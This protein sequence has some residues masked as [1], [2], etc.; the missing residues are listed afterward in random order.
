MA[1][2][3]I[4]FDTSVFIAHLRTGKHKER[5]RTLTGLVRNSSVVLAELLRGATKADE[6]NFVVELAKNHP[7]F[8]PSENNW[9]DSGR[10]LSAV[11]K[12]KGFS[13]DKLR[14]LHFDA[15]IAL[16]ARSHGATVITSDRT[17]FE[18]IRA[19]KDFNLEIW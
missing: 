12:Q 1:G 7:I 4:V 9:L 13:P 2:R 19:Y 16:T 8:T 10:I 15:L 18:L 3:L 17:D 11:N 5:F 6:I 14:D